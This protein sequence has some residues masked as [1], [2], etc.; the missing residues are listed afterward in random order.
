MQAPATRT[1]RHLMASIGL[2]AYLAA[3]IPSAHAATAG[4]GHA[5]SECRS[6]GGF[7][8]IS[9]RGAIDLVVRQGSGDARSLRIQ[10]KPGESLEPKT[11]I[12]VTVDVLRLDTLASAGSGNVNYGG[13]ASTVSKSIGGSGTLC[14]RQPRQARQP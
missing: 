6:V 14:M 13:G 5:A 12:V 9:L 1:R 10:I 11:P 8:A 2:G 7:A 4:S 3:A